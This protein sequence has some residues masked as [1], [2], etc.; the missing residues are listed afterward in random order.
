MDLKAGN[1]DPEV[2]AIK[3]LL[4]QELSL[5]WSRDKNPDWDAFAGT[6]LSS[7][8]LFPSAR[9][10][11]TQTLGQFIDRMK[12]LRDEGKL[13]MFTVTPLG[14]DVRVFG[15]VAIAFAACELLENESTINREVNAT[16]LVR[17]DGMWRIAAQAW[18]IETGACK[19]PDHLVHRHSA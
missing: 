10:V 2:S 13:E 18:D 6:F 1:E 8:T 19:L 3:K 4:H 5:T 7:A 14:C 11:K 9:P 12:Q 15:N 17:E 16:I